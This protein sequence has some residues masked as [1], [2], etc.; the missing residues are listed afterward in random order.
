VSR[1]IAQAAQEDETDSTGG[2]YFGEGGERIAQEKDLVI[3]GK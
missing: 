1:K 3:M 2:E